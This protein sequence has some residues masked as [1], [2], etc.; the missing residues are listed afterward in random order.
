MS[1]KLKQIAIYGKGGIGKSTT[2]SNLSAALSVMGFKVMQ[3]GCDPKSDSTNTL[4]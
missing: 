2:T 3:F 1:G 4:R